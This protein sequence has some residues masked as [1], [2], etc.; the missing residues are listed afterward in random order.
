M[1][2]KVYDVRSSGNNVYVTD[3][4]DGYAIMCFIGLMIAISVVTFFI[5]NLYAIAVGL[6]IILM[7]GGGIGL[8]VTAAKYS[9]SKEEAIAAAAK[10][11]TNE[12]ADIK[13]DTDILLFGG[14]ISAVVIVFGL[15]ILLIANAIHATQMPEIKMTK[16]SDKFFGSD[17]YILEYN[18]TYEVTP[19]TKNPRI[20]I[21]NERAYGPDTNMTIKLDDINLGEPDSEYEGEVCW[22]IKS[23][24]KDYLEP[25]E[26]I[27]VIENNAG[28][29]EK[30]IVS[31][32]DYEKTN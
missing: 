8:L 23:Q 29:V 3:I 9:D 7:I 11:K 18:S 2:S 17:T 14:G 21:T 6:A 15:I 20:C 32:G 19:E 13:G 12:E 25:G 16:N 31:K 1:S 10:S 27:L 28:K 4:S 22:K 30:R 24:D 26:H 5:S